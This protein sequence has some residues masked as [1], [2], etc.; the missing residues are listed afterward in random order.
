M[1]SLARAQTL[2]VSNHCQDEAAVD[3]SG[4]TS[5]ALAPA[6]V[7]DVAGSCSVTLFSGNDSVPILIVLQAF[8]VSYMYAGMTVT[9]YDGANDFAQQLVSLSSSEFPTQLPTQVQV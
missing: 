2:Y 3:I 5:V 4:Y 1:M 6:G 8:D 7:T 9:L